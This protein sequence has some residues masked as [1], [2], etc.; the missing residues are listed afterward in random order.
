MVFEKAGYWIGVGMLALFVSNHFAAR[1]QADFRH[2]ASRS[3]AAV[4]Q[5]AGDATGYI[6]S[7]ESMLGRGGARFVH[8][9][10]ALACAQ[11]RL[12]SVQTVIAQHEASL[13]RVQAERDRFI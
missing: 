11:T 13:A 7:A 3:L 5:V 12:A 4:E 2:L 9:Q 8:T 10:S 1:H 6:A